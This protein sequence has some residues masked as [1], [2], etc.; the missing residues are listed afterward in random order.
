MPELRESRRSQ[1]APLSAQRRIRRHCSRLSQACRPGDVDLIPV[2]CGVGLLGLPASI[3]RYPPQDD[4]GVRGEARSG[5][6][7]CGAN[8]GGDGRNCEGGPVTA[9]TLAGANK[10]MKH[11]S[12]EAVVI[13]IATRRGTVRGKFLHSIQTPGIACLISHTVRAQIKDSI[14]RSHINM[15]KSRRL[16]MSGRCGRSARRPPGTSRRSK[17]DQHDRH[18]NNR[19]CGRGR[20]HRW[21]SCARFRLCK[22]HD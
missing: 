20:G 22:V 19:S 11:K 12:A 7:D 1:T 17:C 8:G 16:E 3:L 2:T 13:E 5:D 18:R 10:I 9:A 15:C 4:V 21:I 6:C 14:V